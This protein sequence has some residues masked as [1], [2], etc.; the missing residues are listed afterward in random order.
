MLHFFSFRHVGEDGGDGDGCEL[1]AS[2]TGSHCGGHVTRWL[3]F[4]APVDILE[5]LL[6][7]TPF[8]LLNQATKGGRGHLLQM[9]AAARASSARAHRGSRLRI[10]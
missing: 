6:L 7:A 9:R 3:T 2:S 5:L 10:A 4:A 8:S 1:E